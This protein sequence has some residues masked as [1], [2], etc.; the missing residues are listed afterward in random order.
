MFGVVGLCGEDNVMTVWLGM[1]FAGLCEER[2][3]G[4][5]LCVLD[6]LLWMWG[7]WDVA[8]CV[9]ILILWLWVGSGSVALDEVWLW[10]RF[11]MFVRGLLGILYV[12]LWLG[13]YGIRY[14]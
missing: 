12:C 2:L 4:L 3:F 14:L 10:L 5:E 9:V 13:N 7:L 6:L 8:I 1:G 11:C